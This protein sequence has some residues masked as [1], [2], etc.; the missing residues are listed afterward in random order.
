[1]IAAAIRDILRA[2]S[3]ISAES[4][5]AIADAPGF[6]IHDYRFDFRQTDAGTWECTSTDGHI[7]SL[8]AIAQV[9]ANIVISNQVRNIGSSPTP[10]IHALE[11]LHVAFNQPCQK[12]RHIYLAGG[13]ADGTYPPPA[14]GKTDRTY[15]GP[16][17]IESHPAG[18]SSNLHLP[19]LMSLFSAHADSEGFYCGM[20]WSGLWYIACGSEED[21]KSTLSLGIKVNGLRLE[22]NEVLRFPDVHIGFFRGGPAEGSNV[23]R[24]YLYYHVSAKYE[25]K[26]VIPAVAYN[27][28]QSDLR[29]DLLKRQAERAAAIGVEVFVI[30][31]GWF[32]GDFPFGVGNW[33]S[34]DGDKLPEGL[35]P[36]A[37][38]TRHL[39]MDF[40][41]WFEPER[42]SENTTLVRQHPDWFFPGGEGRGYHLDLTIPAA[43]QYLVDM[44]GGYIEELDLR[45]IKWDYN[46]DPFKYWEAADTT[47]KVQFGY[48]EGLYEVLDTLMERYPRCR[49]EGCASGGRRIDLG[50]IR[51]S[52]TLWISDAYHYEHNPLLSRYMQG[53]ANCFLPGQL[54][55]TWVSAKPDREDGGATDTA[56]LSRMLGHLGFNGDIAAWSEKA[57]QTAGF[58]VNA[59]KRIRHLLVQRFYQVLP[60]PASMEDWDALQFVD[61]GST[62]S[63]L[64]VFSG[65]TAGRRHVVLMGLDPNEDYAVQD[66]VSGDESRLA[67]AKLLN[68]GFG[69]ELEA[70]G[71]GLWLLHRRN[72]Q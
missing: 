9:G 32:P 51:R 43:R 58:W 54:L 56:I 70:S 8:V 39:G 4:I 15:S 71:S 33:D 26:P 68:D 40:G 34:T 36:L 67:G 7:Q 3:A 66:L 6:T 62:E 24:S 42:A 17:R 46:I 23:L 20:E 25:Q 50:T 38:H 47:L 41:L 53:R 29:G 37:K 1:M 45:W 65:N 31:A 60:T 2:N 10:P 61:N 57:L 16:F 59:Y 5:A 72:A 52:H 35:K 63:A 12:W 13:T 30:D 19:L 64:F 44:M 21:H 28:W 14:F 69:V 55:L 11:P 27:H 48:V 22:P 18:R 49:M